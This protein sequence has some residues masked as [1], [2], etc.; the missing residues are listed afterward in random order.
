MDSTIHCHGWNGTYHLISSSPFGRTRTVAFVYSSL[1]K[2]KEVYIADDIYQLQSANAI[3]NEN[4]LFTQRDLPKTKVYTWKND[5]DNQAIEGIL[6]YPP[7]KFELK[8][9]PLFILIHGGPH[10]ASLN[11]FEANW[12]NWASIA[13]VEGWLVLEPNYSGSTGYG[14]QFVNEIRFHTLSRR[15]R[16]IM[17]AVDNLIK[18][19]I[20]DPNKLNVGGYSY[21]GTLTNW[22]ITQTTRF[23]AALSGSSAIERVLSCGTIDLPVLINYLMGG[24]PWEVPKSYQ[25]QSAIYSLDRIRTPTHIVTAEGDVR[26]DAQQSYILE[27][28]L[29]SLGVPVQLLVFPKEGHDLENDPWHGK[30]KVREELKWLAKYGHGLKQNIS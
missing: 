11:A 12:Y 27:R 3:T 26:V 25:N 30:I 19:G 18:D 24:F 7:G 9:L 15:T 16:D 2:P 5:Q 20:V 23:N 28:G 22:L 17:S 8:K 21:G 13:A 10:S 29:R 14:D 1:E 4:N 6:H